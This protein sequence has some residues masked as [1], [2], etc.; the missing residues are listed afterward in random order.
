MLIVTHPDNVEKIRR[1]LTEQNKNDKIKDSGFIHTM[2]PFCIEF[3]IDSAIEKERPTGRYLVENDRFST[4]WDGKGEPPDWTLY[5]GFVK[6]IM[7]PVFYQV[8]QPTVWSP[9]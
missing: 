7:E 6:P 3:R 9:R 2:R 4:Y 8:N 1:L 5:F